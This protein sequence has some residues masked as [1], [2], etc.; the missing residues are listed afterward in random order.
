MCWGRNYYGQLGIGS[1]TDQNLPVDVTGAA[2]FLNRRQKNEEN[3]V[4]DMRRIEERF[5]E[6]M[7]WRKKQGVGD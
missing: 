5:G 7:T 2:I 4:F 6:R 1:T 3:C